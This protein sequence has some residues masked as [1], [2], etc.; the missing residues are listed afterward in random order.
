MSAGLFACAEALPR[1]LPEKEMGDSLIRAERA[2]QAANKA[3]A[4]AKELA[5]KN[6][7]LLEEARGLL[8][9]AESARAECSSNYQRMLN[10]EEARRKAEA[11]RA[12]R[13][14]KAAAAAAAAKA[15]AEAPSQEPSRTDDPE[16]SP[17]DAPIH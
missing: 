14:R 12:L 13:A 10:S 7:K 8:A 2:A 17:S 9:R 3:A 1:D 6:S 4:E 15:A 5:E 16:Y 11:L